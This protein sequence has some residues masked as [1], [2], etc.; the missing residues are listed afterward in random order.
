VTYRWLDD[1]DTVLAAAGIPFLE[2]GPSGADP[3][4][5][6]SWRNRGRPASTGNFD[7]AGV[8]C[9]H[10]ASPEGTSTQSDLNVIL[11]GNGSAPGPISQ[12][13]IA[14]D[15]TVHLVAAGRANHGGSGMRPGIDS[16]CNDMNALLIGIEV[17]NSGIGEYWPDD[18]TTI[19]GRVVTALCAGY[20]WSLDSVY[21]HATT[22]PPYG[23]CN[24]KIDP[25][26]PWQGQPDLVGSTTWDLELWRAFCASTT[27]PPSPEPPSD[28]GDTMPA[29]INVGSYATLA[30]TGGMCHWIPTPQDADALGVPP[31][32]AQGYR[33]VTVSP[34]FM[35]GLILVGTMPPDLNEGW[36]A[37]WWP[38]GHPR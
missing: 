28:L 10:T 36:F 33:G 16:A 27:A 3:T 34:D 7:V 19:Y 20:G 37:D 18:Q 23:G 2:V 21:L 5:A 12:L 31:P 9:H 4:G 8:L 14:R 15:A 35:K 29:W 22:G 26:G 6:S 1:L 30:M 17:A 38:N 24:S 13:Y 25:A 32:N 11:A